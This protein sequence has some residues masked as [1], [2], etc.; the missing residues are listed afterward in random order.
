[1]TTNHP[2]QLDPA[3]IRP[4]RIDKILYLTYM[5][6]ADAVAMLEHSFGTS[7]DDVET[8]R[9]QEVLRGREVTP[10]TL[11]RYI[12][13]YD[14]VSDVIQALGGK[15]RSIAPRDNKADDNKS[16][17]QSAN[18]SPVEATMKAP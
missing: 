16:N 9:L 10:A 3:L 1:M 11:E 15:K 7:L 18:T 4:G 13:E 2:E 14:T 5:T 12:L 17:P 8:E 6:E